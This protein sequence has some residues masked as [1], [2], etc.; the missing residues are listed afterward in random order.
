MGGTYTKEQ[1]EIL[2]ALQGLAQMHT[3]GIP[4]KH[5]KDLLLWV[6]LNYPHSETRLLFEVGF[7]QEVNRHIY[8]LATEKDEAALKLLSPARIMLEAISAEARSAAGQ[9]GDKNPGKKRGGQGTGQRL[10]LVSDSPGKTVPEEEEG[11]EKLELPSLPIPRKP[12]KTPKRPETPENL[13]D[14]DTESDTSPVPE[15]GD[16]V[17]GEIP[18]LQEPRAE[19]TGGGVESR[20]GVEGSGTGTEAPSR[21]D[22]DCAIG[23]ASGAAAAAV[24]GGEGGFV[25]AGG[26]STGGTGAVPEAAAQMIRAGREACAGPGARGISGKGGSSTAS[27]S[28]TGSEASGASETQAGPGGRRKKRMT[29][30]S[31]HPETG[32]RRSTRI[33]ARTRAKARGELVARRRGVNT[34]SEGEGESEAETEGEA[35]ETERGGDSDVSSGETGGVP[36]AAR[37]RRV[38]AERG[39]G[40]VPPPAASRTRRGRGHSSSSR[41]STPSPVPIPMA[42]IPERQA[43]PPPGGRAVITEVPQPRFQEVYCV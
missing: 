14:S 35:S 34:T 9:L 32:M 15:P 16:P 8:L 38:R 27:I 11:Q 31:Q 13:G 6:R 41:G 1:L 4:K 28:D 43:S 22:R 37:A 29:M 17:G 19:K 10:T 21:G 24:P 7:W 30:T 25:R 5:L 26:H 23:A 12:K 2:A 39:R 33:A 18:E 3:K 36:G 40:R 20:T 42:P